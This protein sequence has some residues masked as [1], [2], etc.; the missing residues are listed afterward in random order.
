MSILWYIAPPGRFTEIVALY[1]PDKR[2]KCFLNQGKIFPN[3]SDASL[4]SEIILTN[5]QADYIASSFIRISQRDILRLRIEKKF[6]SK[7]KK[8]TIS[9]IKYLLCSNKIVWVI[10]FL[11]KK[12]NNALW[13]FR[14]CTE[15]QKVSARDVNPFY[16]KYESRC[17]AITINFK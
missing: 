15:N 2:T 17:L 1:A 14:V 5:G 4:F 12:T 10:K 7:N 8:K 11:Y 9:A 16:H 3:K 13:E 6:I